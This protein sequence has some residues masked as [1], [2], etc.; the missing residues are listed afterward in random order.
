[1]KNQ[2]LNVRGY[3]QM[4]E[5]GL[6]EV[7]SSDA[8]RRLLLF[9]SNNPNYSYGNVLLI[10]QQCPTATR[11]KG[12][13]GWLKEGRCVRAGEKGIRINA[14]FDKKSE[15]E[16]KKYPS[17][18]IKNLFEEEENQF[19]RISVFDIAQTEPLEGAIEA[20]PPAA[21]TEVLED[22][23]IL[24]PEQLE[25]SVPGYS[26]IVHI[27]RE[28]SVLPIYFRGGV[29]SEGSCDG[30]SIT[31]RSDMS[32]LH[33]LRTVINQIVRSWRYG[34]TL[35]AKQMEIEAES[36]AFIVCQHLGLDT[37][38]F[39]FQYIARY[40]LGKEQSFLKQFLD[41]IQ[42]TALYFIDSIEGVQEA[43]RIQYDTT[44]YF[45]FSNLST[46]KR[47]LQS[48]APVYLV[49][50]GKGELLTFSRQAIE[51]HEGPFATER[52]VWFGGMRKA[53]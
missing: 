26:H 35:N 2:E 15:D 37:S 46:A 27:L 19:R 22:G 14:Y 18:K 16:K 25:G 17:S 8:Y 20:H 45:L 6:E 9:V 52:E 30:N 48:G 34:S 10:L 21:H 49:I 43:E 33:T 11:T 40:I 44:E 5:D 51:Q 7:F 28:I 31:I 12:F 32:Q 4:L 42:K 50:P 3:A 1:M 47:L 38:D 53:A 29:H 13:R 41:T 24:E 36:V 39:S 23:H